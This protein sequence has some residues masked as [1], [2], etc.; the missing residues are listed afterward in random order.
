MVVGKGSTDLRAQ[1]QAGEEDEGDDQVGLV[2]GV[3]NVGVT[4]LVLPDVPGVQVDNE[5]E[6]IDDGVGDGGLD[7][8]HH[9]VL[10]LASGV[11]LPRSA[12]LLDHAYQLD[13]SRHDSRHSHDKA[14]AHQEV[15]E[16]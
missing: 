12:V 7:T 16:A 1:H 8:G 10:S 9:G 15:A 2:R 4:L 14:G 11:L 6:V 5:D 3:A 13:V